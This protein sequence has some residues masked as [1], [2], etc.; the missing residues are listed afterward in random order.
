MHTGSI[1]DV[2]NHAKRF[3]SNYQFRSD[4]YRLYYLSL[5]TGIPGIE[6]F[7]AAGDQK[8]LLRQIKAIDGLISGETISGAATVNE[9]PGIEK[10]N[11]KVA[12]PVLLILY[13]HR[14]AAGGSF[15]PA[16]SP[17]SP[18]TI[19]DRV[20]YYYRA[21]ETVKDDALLELSIGMAYL[22]RSMQRQAN[23]RHIMV[24]QAM[25]FIFQYYRLY[26]EKSLRFEEKEGAAMRQQAEYNVGRCFHQIGLLTL[27]VKY[28]ET[29]IQISEEVQGGLGIRDLVFEASHN[30]SLIFQLSGNSSAAKEITEKYLVL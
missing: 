26:Y 28:Y 10:C 9:E 24:L 15:A 19:I 27:A 30:L 4:A 3:I 5:G 11:P 13:G 1:N 23:N 18:V 2:S 7:H 25:T 12:N 21:R 29:A 16:Q 14:L 8:Y 6:Q 17:L 20:D 22:H